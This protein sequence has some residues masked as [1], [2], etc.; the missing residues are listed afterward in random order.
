MRQG[1]G[2]RRQMQRREFLRWGVL[3]GGLGLAAACAPAAAPGPTAVPAKPAEASKPAEVAKP[4]EAVKPAAP[5]P[6]ATAAP[7]AKPAMVK[8][9]VGVIASLAEQAWIELGVQKGILRDEGVEL[10]FSE[11]RDGGTQFKAL[12][13]GEIDLYEGGFG[14]LTPAIEKGADVRMLGGTKPGLAAA[15]YTQRSIERL[16]DLY[17]KE[18]GTATPGS[19]LHLILVGLFQV[20]GLDID[21]VQIVNIGVSTDVFKA[22]QVGKVPAGVSLVTFKP[23]ADQ[24]PNIKTF[25]IFDEQ[26]PD[27]P[28]TGFAAQTKTIRERGDDLV[29]VGAAWMKS[30]RYGIEHVNEVIDLAVDKLQFPRPTMEFFFPWEIDNRTIAPNLEI[31]DRQLTYMQELNMQGK[32]QE[33]VL[34]VEKVFEG[35]IRDRVL[36]QI[37]RYDWKLK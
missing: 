6:A 21:K 31:T 4:A 27:Y 11:Y 13:A 17:G 18:V 29:R 19:F 35:S 30:Y 37:G 9:K 36:A 24:D 26:L 14:S 32:I 12:M 33:S 28:R 15:L 16:E 5:A 22:V 25:L 3:M 1:E 34:P 10:E 8:M 20:K 23:Q 7:A 2:Y